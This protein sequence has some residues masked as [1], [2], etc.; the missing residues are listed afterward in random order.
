MTK[1]IPKPEFK[2]F[3][4]TTRR[5]SKE[6]KNG[7]FFGRIYSLE[8]QHKIP[9]FQRITFMKF[10]VA[11]VNSVDTYDPNTIYA[12]EGC[13][14]PGGNLIAGRWFNPRMKWNNPE[15]FSG[16][17]LWW[18]VEVPTT[19]MPIQPEEALEFLD[20]FWDEVLQLQ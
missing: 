15:N 6:G 19:R 14:F 17:F 2:E 8:Q 20:G 13:V 11:E 12:Y 9:G 1:E 3:W 16:P 4:G 18:N 7:H 10:D 5:G